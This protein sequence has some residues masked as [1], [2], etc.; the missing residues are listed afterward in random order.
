MENQGGR[1]YLLPNVFYDII[2][3]LTP[4]LTLCIG[5]VIGFSLYK[6]I[7]VSIVAGGGAALSVG[8]GILLV[9]FLGYEYGRLAE[10][11]SDIIVAGP[12]HFFRKKQWL[13]DNHDFQR[14]LS[15]QVNY[16]GIDMQFFDGRNKSK[17]SLY[18]FALEHAPFVGA[19][20]LKRY[21]W[22]KLARS[23]AFAFFCLSCISASFMLHNLF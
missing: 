5:L 7:W 22:E 19:D 13:F 11:F 2:V 23:E 17:W 14:D 21:A 1:G 16:L 8:V 18:F 12:I 20:L 10:T 4:T 3:F 6:N 9:F 15:A